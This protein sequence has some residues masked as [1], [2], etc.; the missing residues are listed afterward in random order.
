[1]PSSTFGDHNEDLTV[2]DLVPR[3]TQLKVGVLPPKSKAK[4]QPLPTKVLVAHNLIMTICQAV[5]MQTKDLSY[6]IE[7]ALRN[8]AAREFKFDGYIQLLELL[9][10]DTKPA[11]S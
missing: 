1:M 11:N 5:G 2:D 9:G 10:V 7:Q 4:P 6:D 3:N 8:A